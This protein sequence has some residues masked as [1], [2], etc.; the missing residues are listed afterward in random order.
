MLFLDVV[1]FG[2]PILTRLFGTGGLCS[3]IIVFINPDISFHVPDRL[4]EKKTFPSLA[5]VLFIRGVSLNQIID[6]FL[7]N[8]PSIETF[9]GNILLQSSVDFD[10]EA[11]PG[12]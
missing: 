5:I 4:L 3:I 2:T 6:E 11:H 10:P 9:H 8:L 7:A 1:H 12:V